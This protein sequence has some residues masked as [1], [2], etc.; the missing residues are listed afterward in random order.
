MKA[1]MIEAHMKVAEV[2]A[3][4]SS[5]KRLQVGAIIVKDDKIISLG[6]NG[7]PAGWSNDCEDVMYTYDE[8]DVTEPGWLYDKTTKRWSISKT[9]SEVI[10]AERNALDKLAKYSGGGHGAVMFITHA[11]CLE[12]A[13]SIYTVGISEVFY[14]NDYKVSNGIDFLRACN[15]I[16][17]K[18]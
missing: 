2:Y 12:C 13:K 14:K 7:T 8:R 9:K 6:Y 3:Q 11:P 16:V 5:A 1:K 4:L 15:I 10:H 17:T 18:I